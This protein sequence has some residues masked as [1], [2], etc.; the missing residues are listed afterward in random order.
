LKVLAAEI[1][2]VADQRRVGDK[3]ASCIDLMAIE[4]AASLLWGDARFHNTVS[5]ANYCITV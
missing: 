4:L 5:S 2:R 1:I 3:L